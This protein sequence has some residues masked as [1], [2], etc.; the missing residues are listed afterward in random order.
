MQQGHLS[1]LTHQHRQA[2]HPQVAPFAF[3]VSAARQG[4]GSRGRNVR[5]K[6]RR[7]ER[8]HVRRQLEPPHR[9]PR[10]F[11][12]RP[13]QVLVRDL[14]RQAM[15]S[16]PAKRRGGQAGHPRHTGFQEGRQMT[17]RRGLTGALHGYRQYHFP[18]RGA[19]GRS[20]HPARSVDHP[21]QVQLLGDPH[22]RPD[23]ADPLC[24]HRPRQ[25][26]I[27]HRRRVGRP[28]HG[29]ARERAL[30][31]RIPQRLRG[32]AIPPATNLPLEYVHSF[33]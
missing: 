6:V 21:D 24:T 3:R 11:D 14:R 16:L 31:N 9:R 4:S 32:D 5:V 28:Q 18:D 15:K 22:Q 2:H 17:L 30:P 1:G 27:G 25:S 13:L 12:L 23:V 8:Q 19:A 33:I 29:L 26:Q 10:Q 7:I 20:L